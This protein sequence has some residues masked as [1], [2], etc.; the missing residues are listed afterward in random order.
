MKKNNGATSSSNLT[1]TM[2]TNSSGKDQR[3]KVSIF[4]CSKIIFFNRES[5]VY[6]KII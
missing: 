2:T 4:E 3:K 6:F 1:I 5:K